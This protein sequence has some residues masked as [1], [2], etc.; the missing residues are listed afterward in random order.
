MNL[1]AALMCLAQA[2]FFEARGEPFVG[3]V[4][5][6]SVVMNR[7]LDPRFP[8]DVCAVV[9]QG[10][11]YKNRPDIPLKNKCQFSFYCDGKSDEINM[12]LRSAKESVAVAYFILSGQGLDVTGGATFYHATYVQPYWASQKTRTVRIDKHIFYKWER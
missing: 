3:K 11:V 4:A 8:N 7:T 2:V 9:K 12:V 6:A 5:V 1:T 10:P